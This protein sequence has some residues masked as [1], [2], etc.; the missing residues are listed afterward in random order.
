M[1]VPEGSVYC[2]E[3]M[4]EIPVGIIDK[5]ETGCGLTSVALENEYPTIIAVPTIEVIINKIEQYPNDRRSER[6]FGFYGKTKGKEVSKYLEEVKIPKIIVTYDSFSRLI[7]EIENCKETYRIV[8]DEFSDLLDC[9]SYRDEAIRDLL[10]TVKDF[11]YVS[12]IS[13]T[14]IKREYY[15]EELKYLPEYKINWGRYKTVKV[16]RRKTNKPYSLT[17]NI[18]YKYKISGKEGLLMPNG[19]RSKVAYFFINSVNGIS[20]ILK[21]SKL[22]PEEVRVIC[23]ETEENKDK[24]RVNDI[25]Y[26]IST[27]IS[28]EKPFNFI[29]SKAFK[30]CDFYSETGVI[31]VISNVKS[32]NTLISIDTDIKQ[33]AG[34]IRTRTNPF[35]D[36]IYHIFNTNTSF[37]TKEEFEVIQENKIKTTTELLN[38]YAVVND[39]VKDWMLK[40]VQ[41]SIKNED[42]YIF[43]TKDSQLLF[44]EYAV[45][46]DKR[47]WETAY[48]TYR[49]GIK[50]REAYLDAGF[51]VQ[52]R[53][54]WVFIEDSSFLTGLALGDF[55]TM[56]KNYI[57]NPQERDFIAEKYPVIKEA[58]EVLGKDKIKKLGYRQ[59]RLE[60]EVDF[61]NTTTQDKLLKS[62]KTL[63]VPGQIYTAV[64]VKTKIKEVY[65]EAQINKAA[66]AT[67]LSNYLDIQIKTKRIDGKAV[68]V[69]EIL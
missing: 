8:V 63:F 66:K 34:R 1:L 41:K 19:K 52:K 56:C 46:N 15:P 44:N 13:A 16:E 29:T 62:F 67:D 3:F 25:M 11:K 32:P 68:K 59:D 54:I 10:S 18:I 12:Y 28:E 36:T 51:E 38:S 60:I 20:E 55:E 39:S 35:N 64:E 33:L 61:Y 9:Y 42:D 40:K 14:P 49:N 65:A 22:K 47:R 43:I 2:T 50:V 27:S 5:H 45:I 23:S 21:H 48:D 17:A 31:Y 4:D 37:L 26:P 24:L 69:V 58:F 6:V 57:N 7:K 53:S 30:G